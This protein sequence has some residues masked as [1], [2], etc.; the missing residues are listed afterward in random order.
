MSR[1]WY[2]LDRRT[3]IFGDSI[4]S[5]ALLLAGLLMVWLSGCAEVAQFSADDAEKAAA[6]A[7]FIGDSDGAA[8]WAVLEA[9]GN[10]ISGVGNQPGIV[11]AIE[12]KRAVQMAL[13]N[14][15]CQPVWVEVLS[16]LLKAT[17]AAPFI[18]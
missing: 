1:L 7:T 4:A 5:A 16:Q 3:V 6:I 8:C 18:P 17:P 12:E 15:A 13:Q 14:A 11:V 9:T 2:L 10:A